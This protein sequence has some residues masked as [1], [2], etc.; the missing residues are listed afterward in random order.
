[1]S[2]AIEAKHVME[3]HDSSE[4]TKDEP[5]LPSSSL[6]HEKLKCVWRVIEAW[7]IHNI[8][9]CVAF[10]WLIVHVVSEKSVFCQVFVCFPACWFLLH[11]IKFEEFIEWLSL[12]CFVS[13]H[14]EAPWLYLDEANPSFECLVVRTLLHE[15]IVLKMS[16][17]VSTPIQVG[18]LALSVHEDLRADTT[19]ARH[20]I[21]VLVELG[22][23]VVSWSGPDINL[24]N[25]GWLQI[26]SDAMNHPLVTIDFAVIF[27][28]EGEHKIHFSISEII[29]WFDSKVV[30]C[31]TE[32]V[33]Q[34]VWICFLTLI[35]EVLNWSHLVSFRS[36]IILSKAFISK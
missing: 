34:V 2:L 31:D 10:T 20:I 24:L 23:G 35:H 25:I 18:Y 21:Q 32:D 8:V 22:H 9:R 3:V 5:I 6:L 4:W 12:Y 27:V 36:L 11:I 13:V 7:C 1:V 26:L 14:S 29:I 17:H 16:N 28:L 19:A 30:K 33:K 15:F